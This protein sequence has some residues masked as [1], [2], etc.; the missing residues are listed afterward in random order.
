MAQERMT[1]QLSNQSRNHS[2]DNRR[3]SATA[4]DV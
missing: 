3:I 4:S 2:I 1:N